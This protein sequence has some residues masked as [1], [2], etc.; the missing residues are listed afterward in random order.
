MSTTYANHIIQTHNLDNI[1]HSELL[2]FT[3]LAEFTNSLF[4]GIVSDILY[5]EII[6]YGIY[7]RVELGLP[8]VTI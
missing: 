5:T 4:V 3:T 8:T 2:Q 1:M 6:N 7:A